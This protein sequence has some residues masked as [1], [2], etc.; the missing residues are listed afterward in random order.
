MSPSTPGSG[1]LFVDLSTAGLGGPNFAGVDPH[2]TVTRSG[3]FAAWSSDSGAFAKGGDVAL[4][5]LAMDDDG[6]TLWT[7]NLASQA[8]VKMNIGSGPTPTAP[9]SIGS[10]PV[11]TT[12][13]TANG[14]GKSKAF[15]VA[16]H[17]GDVFVGG[18]C[19]GVVSP[20]VAPVAFVYR[21]SAG[22]YSATPVLTQDMGY[23]RAAGIFGPWGNSNIYNDPEPMLTG[24]TFA[25]EDM[26]LGFRVRDTPIA[27]EILRACQSAAAT[28]LV[29]FNGTATCP[30]SASTFTQVGSSPVT[31]PGGGSSIG[32]TAA[33]TRNK[34]LA[35]SPRWPAI[36][37]CRRR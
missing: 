30:Y 24:I 1:S 18:V 23:I 4:G 35:A 34:W 31:G 12:W 9:T 33:F 20:G 27:G 10:Y 21:F 11:P 7:V 28:W 14:K 32:A 22:V 26:V 15:A 8:L 13:C 2:T 25:D 3:E 36:R 16:A 6:Q 29:E 5:G 17:D 19:A 37:T